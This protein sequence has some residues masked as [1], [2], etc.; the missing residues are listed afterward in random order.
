LRFFLWKCFK[1]EVLVWKD[2]IAEMGKKNQEIYENT[3][4]QFSVV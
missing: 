1:G 2:I 4:A 3:P